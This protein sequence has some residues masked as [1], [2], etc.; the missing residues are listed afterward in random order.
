MYQ[1]SDLRRPAVQ[2]K[3]LQ[4]TVLLAH[5]AHEPDVKAFL[6]QQDQKGVCWFVLGCLKTVT[7]A[8]SSD[9]V[10]WSLHHVVDVDLGIDVTYALTSTNE[11]DA[12]ACQLSLG[13]CVHEAA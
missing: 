1:C 8:E 12:Y 10:D 7:V 13:T 6:A 3:Q 2:H 4:L 5:D 11:V 9:Q